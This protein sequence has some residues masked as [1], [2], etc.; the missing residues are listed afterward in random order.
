MGPYLEEGLCRC[1][2]IKRRAHPN[3]RTGVHIGR[4][5]FGH[6]DTHSG[7]SCEDGG[8]GGGD[9]RPPETRMGNWDRFSLRGSRRNNPVDKVDTL[10]SDF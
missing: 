10:I 3:P 1:N 4:G 8:R 2:H 6:R 7:T 5:N 9:V